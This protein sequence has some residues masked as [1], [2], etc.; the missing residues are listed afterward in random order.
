M[1]GKNCQHASQIMYSEN[2]RKY[3]I[4]LRESEGS[5]QATPWNMDG[6][7]RWEKTF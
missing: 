6:I 5:I 4:Q 7:Y 1:Q 2:W 3:H